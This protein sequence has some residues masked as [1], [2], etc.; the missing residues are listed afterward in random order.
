MGLEIDAIRT[1][2]SL[3]GLSESSIA[4]TFFYISAL[5]LGAV[6][7]GSVMHSD[8]ESLVRPVRC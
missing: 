1:A 5:C 4:L 3:G 2:P 6:K 7:L 8:L